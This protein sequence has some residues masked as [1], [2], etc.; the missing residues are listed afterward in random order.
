MSE[1]TR[2]VKVSRSIAIPGSTV[3]INEKAYV[4]DDE[5]CI[6]VPLDVTD[7]DLKKVKDNA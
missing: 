7:E 5:L 3:I 2:R 6:E 4:V 1:E